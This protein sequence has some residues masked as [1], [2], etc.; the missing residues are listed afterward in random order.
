MRLTPVRSLYP[1]VRAWDAVYYLIHGMGGNDFAV[2]DRK[3]AT[4][5][6]DGVRALDGVDRIVYLSGLVPDLA[7]AE[8]SEHIPV[9]PG[10]L[11]GFSP[12][13]VPATVVVLRAA[14]APGRRS[15]FCVGV[16]PAGQPA[17][18]RVN[19]AATNGLDGAAE[20]P[21]STCSRRWSA[22]SSTPALAVT[23]RVGRPDQVAAMVRSMTPSTG[24]A[25]VTPPQVGRAV[26]YRL[27]APLR[28]S[29]SAASL[30]GGWTRGRGACRVSLRHDR[31]QGML[32]FSGD[33]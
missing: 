31:S 22:R 28:H 25:G 11:S 20:G 10:S 15:P 2:P 18:A 26:S 27:A 23:S 30:L 9:P 4:N 19:R 1:R 5:L 7:D 14:A 32:P 21:R 29:W 3:A 6:A 16:P 24:N 8:L 13:C 17:D 33:V 12:A